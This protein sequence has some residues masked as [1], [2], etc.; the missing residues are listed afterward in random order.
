MGIGI[1][2]IFSI[3]GLGSAAA[4]FLLY[5]NV[6]LKI[7]TWT[8]VAGTVVGYR[9]DHYRNPCSYVPQV[10]FASS[11]GRLITWDYNQGIMSP[12]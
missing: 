1:G 4:A 3:F 8:T 9:E 10:Q 11:D 7:R 6:Y 5:R 2:I 12:G